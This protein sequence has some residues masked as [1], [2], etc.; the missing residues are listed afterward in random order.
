MRRVIPKDHESRDL[1][2]LFSVTFPESRGE[3]SA[4]KSNRRTQTYP[5][6]YRL[7]RKKS[8]DE[9]FQKIDFI[10]VVNVIKCL[11]LFPL[12]YCDERCISY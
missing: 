2:K 5:I 4:K 11:L 9:K 6:H 3:R 1:A 7:K 10:F 8:S 12:R